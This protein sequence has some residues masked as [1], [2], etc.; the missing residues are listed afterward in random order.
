MDLY[1][2]LVESELQH[3][4]NSFKLIFIYVKY[5]HII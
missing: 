2:F 5:F 1:E 3:Y 4:Y